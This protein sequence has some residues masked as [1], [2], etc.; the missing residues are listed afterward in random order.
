[1]SGQY[2]D[3][4]NQTILPGAASFDAAILLPLGRKLALEARVENLAD[5]RVDAGI[6]DGIVERATPRTLWIGFRFGGLK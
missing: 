6:S 2:E 5:A 4:L 3:D 1:V